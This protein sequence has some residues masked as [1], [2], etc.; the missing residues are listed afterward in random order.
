MLLLHHSE[1][2]TISLNYLLL[3]KPPCF[4]IIMLKLTKYEI[5][6]FNFVKVHNSVAF[7]TFTM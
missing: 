4:I 7:S 2:R 1:S 6:Y 3:F 5:Q